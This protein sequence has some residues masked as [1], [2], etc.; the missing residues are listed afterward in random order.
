MRRVEKLIGADIFEWDEL[1]ESDRNMLFAA[2]G[3]RPNAQ[4]PYSGFAVGSAVRSASGTIFLG[5]NV[6]EAAYIVDH[7][8]AVARTRMICGEGSGQKIVEVAIVA[9]FADQEVAL[10]PERI[11]DPIENLDDCTAPCGHCRQKI[12]DNAHGDPNVRLIGLLL[13]GEICITTIGDAFP[14]PFGPQD[15]GISYEK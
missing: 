14:M 6:E 15:L 5:V 12:W 11:G 3:I 10:P 1:T 7:A 8:E 2:A 9:A 13:N 4:C